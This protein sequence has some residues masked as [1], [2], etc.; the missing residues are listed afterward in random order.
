MAD[1]NWGDDF[2]EAIPIEGEDNLEDLK[3]LNYW[4]E[5]DPERISENFNV[6]A[7]KIQPKITKKKVEKLKNA[8][9]DTRPLSKKEQEEYFFS[10]IRLCK[11]SDFKLAADL[12]DI[13]INTESNEQNEYNEQ[14]AHKEQ[15]KC[16]KHYE[17]NEY[18][19]FNH[20][21]DS[22]IGVV[23]SHVDNKHYSHF[24]EDLILKMA[25][26]PERLV[27]LSTQLSVLNAEKKQEQKKSSKKKKS[28]ISLK[29]ERSINSDLYNDL[30]YSQDEV[31]QPIDKEYYLDRNFM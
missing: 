21:K 19:D 9:I 14:S 10:I 18:S 13:V 17:Y 16:N 12:F 22:M 5:E 15:L 29:A 28:K 25:I 31:A 3:T 30:D 7:P 23:E 11:K 1:D 4:E 26:K 24:V 20:L 8:I 27:Y 6:L 2:Q